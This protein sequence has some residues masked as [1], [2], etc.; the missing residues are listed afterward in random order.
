MR[1]SPVQVGALT[2]WSNVACGYEHIIAT[3]TDG[4]LWAWGG[5]QFGQLGLGNITSRSSPV[6]VGALTTWSN[7][8]CGDG[9]N[10]ATTE[11]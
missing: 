7:I 3:K 8:A 11:E 5:N 1:S 10:I 4:T 2:T 9:H 6:Q